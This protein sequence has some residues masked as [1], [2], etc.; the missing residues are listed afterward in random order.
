MK[1]YIYLLIML[2]VGCAEPDPVP[3]GA[4]GALYVRRIE[5]S[6]QPRFKY[7]V[8]IATAD[9]GNIETGSGYSFYTNTE[10]YVGQQ[11]VSD[12]TVPYVPTRNGKPIENEKPGIEI[13][14]VSDTTAADSGSFKIG[15]TVL[16]T[17]IP[18]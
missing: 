7:V 11:I 13:T 3:S 1:N 6:D 9:D 17:K 8:I 18:K 14:I 12:T 5:L 16:T 15:D 2:M 4:H 10:L